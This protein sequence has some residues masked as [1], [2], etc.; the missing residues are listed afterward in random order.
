MSGHIALAGSWDQHSVILGSALSVFSS[1]P[2]YAS[3]YTDLPA[4]GTEIA[5]AWDACLIQLPP[6]W[7]TFIHPA[8]PA[9][10]TLLY[11]V[12]LDSLPSPQ[13]SLSAICCRITWYRPSKIAFIVFYCNLS[14]YKVYLLS[15]AKWLGIPQT[16][17]LEQVHSR[18]SVDVCWMTEWS[19]L[20]A[21][22]G[23]WDVL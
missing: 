22:S 2:P 5:S 23:M 15:P 18:P 6:P 12:C 3:A 4:P 21:N 11:T 1:T 7:G 10:V 20:K 8:Y 16:Y 9:Q 14:I 19:A 17:A 13:E